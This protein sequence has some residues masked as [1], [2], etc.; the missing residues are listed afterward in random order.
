MGV[1]RF[2]YHIFYTLTPFLSEGHEWHIKETWGT[3]Y[4]MY[5]VCPSEFIVMTVRVQSKVD[6]IDLLKSL[7]NIQQILLFKFSSEFLY[8]DRPP[9]NM[10]DTIL[11]V[12]L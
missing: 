2:Y 6:Y 7:P 10:T 3:W 4:K 9:D 5:S 12:P 8:C 11:E 1:H